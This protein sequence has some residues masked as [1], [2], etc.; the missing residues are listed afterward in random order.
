MET[1]IRL[2]DDWWYKGK[3]CRIME[4]KDETVKVR[5]YFAQDDMGNGKGMDVIIPLKDFEKIAEFNSCRIRNF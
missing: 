4:L 3:L 2:S 1:E 5:P